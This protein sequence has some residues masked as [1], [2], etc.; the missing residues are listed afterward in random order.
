MGT[1][2]TRIGRELADRLDMQFVDMDNVIVEQE[3][4]PIPRIFAEDGEPHFRAVE[5]TVVQELAAGEGM[6]IA[7]GGGVVL[8]PE[9]VR[10]LSHSG[11]VVCLSATPRTILERVEHDTNRPLLAEGDKLTKIRD[12]LEARRAFY[13]AI[14]N[15]VVTD[16]KTPQQVVDEILSLYSD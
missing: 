11:L 7:T 12:L 10:D 13:A 9:N 6:V 3:G 2:K 4:K 8:N 5:R 1:G 16:G 15:Q 14:P